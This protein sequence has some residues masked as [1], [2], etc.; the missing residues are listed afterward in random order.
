M[1]T[2]PTYLISI[3]GLDFCETGV[4]QGV[5]GDWD[6][7]SWELTDEQW[8]MAEPILRPPRREDSRRRPWRDT[9]VALNCVSWVLG[10]AAKWAEMWAKGRIGVLDM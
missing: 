10:S 6:A 7:D 3:S 2:E 8:E 1:S 9:R 5:Y 4:S